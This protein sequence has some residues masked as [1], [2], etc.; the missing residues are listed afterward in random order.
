MIAVSHA[1]G[2]YG[3]VSQGHQGRYIDPGAPKL[4]HADIGLAALK[5]HLEF[6]NSNCESQNSAHLAT[7]EA[8]LAF[9]SCF[10]DGSPN[11]N[12]LEGI[13]VGKSVK[14]MDLTDSISEEELRYVVYNWCYISCRS[15]M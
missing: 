5:Y 1:V 9:D 15:R 7:S 13:M 8:K 14:P 3:R 11:T 2:D 6:A 12:K 10:L 4:P